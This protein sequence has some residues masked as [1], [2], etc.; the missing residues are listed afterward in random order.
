MGIL[1]NGRYE[2]PSNLDRL[3]EFL[4]KPA[5][6]IIIALVGW[7]PLGFFGQTKGERAGGVILA[8]GLGITLPCTLLAVGL[9]VGHLTRAIYLGF[10]KHKGSRDPR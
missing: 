4:G 1:K 5:A 9:V 3:L 8:Y 2:E 6:L 7:L 10:R